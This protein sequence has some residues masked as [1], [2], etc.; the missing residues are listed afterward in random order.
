[1]KKYALGRRKFLRG[2]GGVALALPFLEA[3]EPRALAQTARPKRIIVMGYMMGVP[4]EPWRPSG[5][6]GNLRLSHITA[7]FEPIKNKC[8]F[9]SGS[10]RG[11]ADMHS[12]MKYGHQGKP[13]GAFTGTL[14]VALFQ[15][16]NNNNHLD[17]VIFSGLSSDDYQGSPANGESIETL[18]GRSIRH[19][20]HSRSGINLSVGGHRNYQGY[21]TGSGG[22]FWEGRGAEVA[23]EFNPKKAF[24]DVF[25][26]LVNPDDTVDPA[27]DRLR[28]RNASVLDAVREN[29]NDLRRDLGTDDQQRL[30][31][32]AQRIREIEGAIQYSATC[33]APVFGPGEMPSIQQ[34]AGQSDENYMDQIFGE[35]NPG[36]RT[37]APMAKTSPLMVQ[38]LAHAM[39][40]DIAPVGRLAFT[41]GDNPF[42]GIPSVDGQITCLLYTS[43]S[44]RDQRGSRM[45]SSA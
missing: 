35:P 40:C 25:G 10:Y 5:D 2:A 16:G 6:D 41:N 24:D 18:V 21:S 17:N 37:T 45:P 9:L 42:F 26:D 1:M 29:F 32:H 23:T 31:A 20:G 38:I 4:F 19:S 11:V 27:L 8:L 36:G 13:E 43:P 30:D 33:S 28:V 39:A 14:P 22:F 44:P 15:S 3:F 12:D 7:P 34:S